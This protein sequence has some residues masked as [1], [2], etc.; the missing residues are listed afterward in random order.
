M[1]VAG[2]LVHRAPYV[3][4]RVKAMMLSEDNQLQAVFEFVVGNNTPGRARHAAQRAAAVAD[5]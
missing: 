3:S 4:M 1:T 2:E 5:G